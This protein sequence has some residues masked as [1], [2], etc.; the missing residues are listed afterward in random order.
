M[1]EPTTPDEGGKP[2]K[3]STTEKSEKTFTQDEIDEIVEKRLRRERSKFG[4]YDDLRA[5]AEKLDKIEK[6]G[7]SELEQAIARAEAAERKAETAE[8]RALRMEVA[9]DKGLTFS[10]AK[11]LVGSTREE[12]EADADELVE[13]FGGGKPD[14][15][16]GEPKPGDP[17]E[18]EGGGKPDPRRRPQERLRS[19]AV[20]AAEPEKTADEIADAIYKSPQI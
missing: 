15:K 10:Q 12:L 19:G 6:D 14:P 17:K 11:R 2:D 16:E 13:T 7:Q 8:S 3:G 9:L 18:G 20:P 4:D 5:K 1:A